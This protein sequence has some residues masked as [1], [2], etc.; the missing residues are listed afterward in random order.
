MEIGLLFTKG[1]AGFFGEFGGIDVEP[2]GL[3]V[4]GVLHDLAGGMGEVG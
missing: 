4:D 2:G 1:V 3:K